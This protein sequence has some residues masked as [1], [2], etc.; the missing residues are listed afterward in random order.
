MNSKGWE[1]L[2]R[3]RLREVQMKRFYEKKLK[4]RI[5]NGLKA[6]RDENYKRIV[7]VRQ[8]ERFDILWTKRQVFASWLNKLDEKNEINQM[9]IV[10]KARRHYEHKISLFYLKVWMSYLIERR[11]FKVI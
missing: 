8:A 4:Q 7:Q 2:A 11:K 1:Y 3:S 6:N 5:F 10:Y 9:H